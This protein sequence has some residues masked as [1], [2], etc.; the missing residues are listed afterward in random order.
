MRSS[1][2]GIKNLYLMLILLIA[3]LS[4][5]ILYFSSFV[6]TSITETTH[7][8]KL[9][10]ISYLAKRLL[11]MAYMASVS[12]GPLRYCERFKRLTPRTKSI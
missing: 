10:Q 12:L 4:I 8:L 7:G 3:L 5:H 9:V 1:N 6:K 2:L 11:T